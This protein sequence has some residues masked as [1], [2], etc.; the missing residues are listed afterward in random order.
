MLAREGLE[1]NVN[2]FALNFEDCL[3]KMLIFDRGH[4]SSDHHISRILN[5]AKVLPLADFAEVNLLYNNRY[6]FF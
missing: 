4:P 6:L 1:I 5:S 3:V 2:T